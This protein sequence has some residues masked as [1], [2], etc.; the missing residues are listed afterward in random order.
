MRKL[1]EAE[2][3][4]IAQP[5]LYRLK[6]GKRDVYI[7]DEEAFR[8]FI[9]TTSTDSVA[10]LDDT[11]QPVAREQTQLLIRRVLKRLD[12]LERLD[13]RTDPKAAVAWAEEGM[14]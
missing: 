6:K 4:Y 1:V 7:K 11:E 9:V 5:P 3:L 12:V 2:H 10:L 8:E 13:R 14:N